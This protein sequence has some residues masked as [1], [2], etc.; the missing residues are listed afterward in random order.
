MSLGEK[1]DRKT[2]MLSDLTVEKD[3]RKTIMLSDLKVE[4]DVFL[5]DS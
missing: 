5:G 1:D 2:I 3:D 4:K